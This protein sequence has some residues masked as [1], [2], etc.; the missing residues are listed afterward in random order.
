MCLPHPEKLGIDM[1]TLTLL[2]LLLLAGCSTP[3]TV[4]YR[5]VPSWLIPSPPELPK[6]QSVDLKCLSDQTYFDLA[7]RDRA[8]RNYAA[9]LRA[10]LEATPW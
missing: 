9:E 10:L 7:S 8:L 2:A 1:R 5:P 3:P 4:E 6:I